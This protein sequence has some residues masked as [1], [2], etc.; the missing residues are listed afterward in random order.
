MRLT[1]KE[2]I[3]K[4]MKEYLLFDELFRNDWETISADYVRA[5]NSLSD[6]KIEELDAK[7]TAAV[8]AGYELDDRTDDVPDYPKKPG[9]IHTFLNWFGIKTATLR[10]YE[11]EVS[12]LN[13]RANSVYEKAVVVRAT[14]EKKNIKGKS[15]KSEREK[16][17]ESKQRSLDR[18]KEMKRELIEQY[19][20]Q[21]PKNNLETPEEK[22][23]AN[24]FVMC[25][26]HLEFNHLKASLGR[27]YNEEQLGQVQAEQEELAKSSDKVANYY[28]EKDF[29]SKNFV[30]L[31]LK[32]KDISSWDLEQFSSEYRTHRQEEYVKADNV[33]ENM[34]Q[35]SQE[36]LVPDD[37]AKSDMYQN[38]FT[39][40][41]AKLEEQRQKKAFFS[42]LTMRA[43]NQGVSNI[44]LNADKA[45]ENAQNLMTKQLN[46]IDTKETNKK[47]E[48]YDAAVQKES[49]QNAFFSRKAEIENSIPKLVENF[50]TNYKN[51]MDAFKKEYFNGQN[52]TPIEIEN[53]L[54]S[55]IKEQN[56]AIKEI[57]QEQKVYNDAY[58]KGLD[59]NEDVKVLEQSLKE[60]E[61]ELSEDDGIV[62]DIN[63]I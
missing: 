39:E 47:I 34:N 22:A 26:N 28:V 46:D 7:V 29:T 8:E 63:K 21:Y 43:K 62:I 5:Y 40:L 27:G 30:E 1:D 15:E 31:G 12:T 54:T 58:S 59:F 38:K 11:T 61:K 52:P 49:A 42:S 55:L 35:I 13:A 20:A 18:I 53:K 19:K 17:Y 41:N 24:R 16:I 10:N 60:P 56:D 14:I 33:V 36:V 6:E 44:K 37:K 50:N 9:F 57:E 48:A 32:G 3:K 51:N 4:A 45:I 25:Y 23:A 2:E